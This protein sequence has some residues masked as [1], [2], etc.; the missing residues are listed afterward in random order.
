MSIKGKPDIASFIDGGD[1][2]GAKNTKV[3]KGA[4]TTLDSEPK[5]KT[6]KLVELPEHVSQ[7]LRDRAYNDSKKNARRVTETEIIVEALTRYLY[8]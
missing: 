7:A 6:R 4:K 8:M 3:T 1:L 5:A 2:P